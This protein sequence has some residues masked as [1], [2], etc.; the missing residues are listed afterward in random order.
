MVLLENYRAFE[1]ND[2]ETVKD[3]V[4]MFQNVARELSEVAL[5]Y[6]QMNEKAN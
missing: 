5:L 1:S 6:A 3:T 4:G 2:L